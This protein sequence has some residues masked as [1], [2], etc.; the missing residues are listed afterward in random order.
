MEQRANENSLGP[1]DNISRPSAPPTSRTDHFQVQV[2]QIILDDLVHRL[3]HL[4][5]IKNPVTEIGRGCGPNLPA[6]AF[7]SNAGPNLD[8]L[9]C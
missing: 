7:D 2:Y 4:R 3:F 6:M 8:N 5:G 9:E 1:P